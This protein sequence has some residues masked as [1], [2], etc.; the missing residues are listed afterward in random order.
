MR[1]FIRICLY[2]SFGYGY[3]FVLFLFSYSVVCSASQRPVAAQQC[4]HDTKDGRR[5]HGFIFSFP[6]T[7]NPKQQCLYSNYDVC[8]APTNRRHSSRAT[9]LRHRLVVGVL[10]CAVDVDDGEKGSCGDH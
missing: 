5:R 3:F 4:L 2:S 9:F 7:R 6:S 1:L 8:F 10:A